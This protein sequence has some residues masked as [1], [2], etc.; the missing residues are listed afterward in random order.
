MKARRYVGA[1]VGKLEGSAEISTTIR[2]RGE[3]WGTVACR[4]R[5]DDRT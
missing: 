2:K 5:A 4:Q 3:V 1:W